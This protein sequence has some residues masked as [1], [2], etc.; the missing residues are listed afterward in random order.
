MIHLLLLAGLDAH[1]G[2]ND[3][4]INEVVY[5]VSG[6]DGGEEW[7]EICNDGGSG[8]SLSGWRLEVTSSGGWTEAFSLSS[9][10][11]SGHGHTLIGKGSGTHPGTFSPNIPNAGSSTAGIRLLDGSGVVLDTLLY[12]S[13]N[14]SSYE[15]DAGYTARLAPTVGADESLARVPDCTD[16]DDASDDF[17]RVATPTPGGDNG[18]GSSDCP[19]PG[20]VIN[21][22]LPDP[23]S[24]GGD[25]GHEWVELF[26]DGSTT[27]DLG[28]WA[29][30]F[31]TS[32]FSGSVSLPGGTSLAPGAYLL[33]GDSQVDDTDVVGTFTMGNAGSD[34]D[35]VR[36]VDCIGGPV[37]TVIYGE[38]NED[39]WV[40]DGG[41]VATS[42]AVD[43]ASGAS[44]GRVEDGEDTNLSWDDF[45]RFDAPTPGR[46]NT[47]TLPCD[48]ED[49]LLINEFLPDPDGTDDGFEW[50]ELVNIGGG[51]ISLDGWALQWG[52]SSYSKSFEFSSSTSISAGEYL[53]IGG[54]GV[55]GADIEADL[56]MGNAGSSGDGLRL[57]HCGGGAADTVVYGPDNSD[58]W[59]DD[60]GIDASSIA[61]EPESGKSLARCL[62]GVDTDLSARDFVVASASS[63]GAAN[64]ECIPIECHTGLGTIKLN[65]L[66]PDPSGTDSGR[67][68]V[69]LYNAGTDAQRLDAW[70]LEKATKDWSVA[71]TFPGGAEIAAGAFLL[72]G[73][74]EVPADHIASSLTLGN[75]GTAPD[76]LRLLDCGEF[77]V[78]QD[79][80][81]W[82]DAG[83][84]PEDPLDDDLG[85]QSMA[86]MPG[87]DRT[88]GRFPDGVD[89]DDN[90]IDFSSNMNPTPGAANQEGG[91]SDG[92]SGPGKGCSKT[93][94][95]GEPSKCGVAAPM[96]GLEW[97]ILALVGLRRRR[98]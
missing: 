91:G 88:V 98:Y 27:A 43:P 52:T 66:L 7:I 84:D 90:S 24:E 59:K 35:G 54:A 82:G 4:R 63:L 16:S 37:D 89:S 80:V 9:G 93:A 51:S 39:G 65:E 97:L 11:V 19:D 76:G 14:S 78:L 56:D 18:D 13:P 60:G 64:P 42:L 62:D 23:A 95:D 41:G 20:V 86:E 28:G 87:D 3:I 74:S 61:P 58:G 10:T 5:D 25:V 22:F 55:S 48:G 44:I 69:E 92:G 15:D 72:V 8:V 94:D 57:V 26:N 40:D 31:G 68:W 77:P 36:L 81:L 29:I 75:G 6:T 79:T 73:A 32:S 85:D 17:V 71:F 50:V 49:D 2:T 83:E 30:E 47:E 21:E 70:I 96:G 34:A 45:D 33:V 38:T 12:G 53:V 67:E 1:A 46:S